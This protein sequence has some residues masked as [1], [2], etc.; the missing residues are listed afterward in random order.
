MLIAIRIIG[1]KKKSL[2]YFYFSPFYLFV[3]FNLKN[4]DRYSRQRIIAFKN[5]IFFL[6]FIHSD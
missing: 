3:K 6:I 2:K 4:I 1:K 5:A